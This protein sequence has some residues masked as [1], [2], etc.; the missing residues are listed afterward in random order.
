MIALDDLKKR[1]IDFKIKGLEWEVGVASDGDEDI[2]RSY[3]EDEI[4][5]PSGEKVTEHQ[6][7]SFF[8][9][10]KL[11]FGNKKQI[12]Y[13]LALD[14][15]KLVDSVPRNEDVGGMLPGYSD[16]FMMIYSS[17]SSNLPFL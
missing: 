12:E 10:N 7:K 13:L 6:V 14:F 4:T 1:L 8:E 17:F 3:I 9:K 16:L 15:F 11:E 5:L 2:P